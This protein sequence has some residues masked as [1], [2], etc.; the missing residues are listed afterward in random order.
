MTLKFLY[1]LHNLTSVCQSLCFWCRHE[2]T[3]RNH[4]STGNLRRGKLQGQIRKTGKLS[5]CL[6]FLA[7][8]LSKTRK[9]RLR[10][11]MLRFLLT[12][13]V[14]EMYLSILTKTFVFETKQ[15]LLHLCVVS[16]HYT[17]SLTILSLDCS[18]FSKHYNNTG[19]HS[20]YSTT[21][22]LDLVMWTVDSHMKWE[23]SSES[24]VKL[25]V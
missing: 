14:W 20:I 15:M 25:G 23:Q 11:L 10:F 1:R 9:L 7:S 5:L 12:W 8:W 2:H 19:P 13:N 4:R 3:L 17:S 16:E 21:W 6:S 18:H 22:I 24:I